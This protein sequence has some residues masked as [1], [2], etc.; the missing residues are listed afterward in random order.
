MV[1]EPLTLDDVQAHLLAYEARQIRHH[2]AARLQVGASAHVAGRGGPFGRR[3][4]GTGRGRGRGRAPPSS[5]RGVPSTRPR[6]R[7]QICD[8]EG[9]SAIRCWYRMDDAYNEEPPSAAVAATSSY[10][11]DP[12]WYNDTGAMDHITS[13][14]DRLT[15]RENYNGGDTVQVSNGQGLQI[16]HTGYSSL[17]TDSRP[18][19]LNN[20]LHVPQISKH[21]LSVHKLTR[22]NNV[23]FEFDPWYYLIKDRETRQLLLE[24]RCES[25][26][27]PIKPS[28]IAS[29]FIKPLCRCGQI[30][31]MHVLVIRHR[32][33]LGLFCVFIIYLI[34]KS[35][36]YHRFVMPVS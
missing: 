24:G 12:R 17:N 35:P 15:M 21:L 4:R 25:G 23:F 30:S 28:D 31:G 26:L 29:L 3:G 1:S 14:L 5:G 36:V 22:D 10:Q 8:K 33:S 27:Y 16:L 13:D 19:A 2:T 18:L 11:L 34:P 20:V 32:K 9:H 7:C 6:V